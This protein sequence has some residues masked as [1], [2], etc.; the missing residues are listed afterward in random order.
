MAELRLQ[1][2]ASGRISTEDLT[3]DGV[4]KV[5]EGEGLAWLDILRPDK[6][7]RTFLLETM[8]FEE[9]AVEDAFGD[10]DTTAQKFQNHRF[11]VVKARDTDNRLDTEPVAAFITENLLITVRHSTIPPLKILARRFR[12]A[13]DE[14]LSLGVDFLLYEMLDAIADDWTPILNTYSSELDELEFQVFDPN[15]QYDGVL[16]GLHNLKRKLRESSKSIES[17]NTVTMRLLKPNERLI[18]EGVTPY[19]SDLNQLSLALVKRAN[20]YASGATSARDSYLSNIS[21]QLAESNAQLTEVM[22]TLTIIGAI[23][24]PLTLIAGIFGMNND[25]LPLELV[26]GFWGIIAM[27]VAFAVLMLSFFWRRGWLKTFTQ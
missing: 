24:L 26:G 23:M 11:I 12:R 14:Q 27:M 13:D 21:M 18:S 9:L 20:N 1:T 5:I 15:I 3:L 17:L 6:E 7:V 10:A 4:L 2:A 25:D 19:F 8:D 16:E 22:T